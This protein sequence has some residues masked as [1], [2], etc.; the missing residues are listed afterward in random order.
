M[1]VIDWAWLSW[2][3]T[4]FFCCIP[5]LC[6]VLRF[7]PCYNW[8][9]FLIYFESLDSLC[10]FACLTCRLWLPAP[11]WLLSPVSC[12]SLCI[13]FVLPFLCQF[14]CS[15]FIT[16]CLIQGLHF[17]LVSVVF[18]F[19]LL[20]VPWLLQQP[21]VAGTCLTISFPDAVGVQVNVVVLVDQ[22]SSP[23]P[24]DLLG[25]PHQ[26]QPVVFIC[27]PTYDYV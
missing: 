6:V 22:P 26:H 7:L 5:L 14:V 12:F 1:L 10:V 2:P 20:F 9:F 27:S 19:L 23:L 25:S 18:F 11:P 13:S 16:L 8:V 15:L 24:L 3:A 4:T 17:W 21:H